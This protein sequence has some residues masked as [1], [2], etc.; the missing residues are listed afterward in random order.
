MDD[1]RR[2]DPW[3]GA[4]MTHQR[5]RLRLAALQHQHAAGRQQT[6]GLH[7]QLEKIAHPRGHAIEAQARF[8]ADI[9]RQPVYLCGW[10][11]RRI[12]DDAVK[13]AVNPAAPIPLDEEDPP[14]TPQALR[15]ESGGANSLT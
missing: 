13:R 1:A 12:G 14:R 11:V 3:L 15:V 9:A 4:D 5:I 8:L 10:N 6:L 2:F 7:D